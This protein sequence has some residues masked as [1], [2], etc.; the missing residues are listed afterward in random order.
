MFGPFQ[1]SE[2]SA[3]LQ[4]HCLIGSDNMLAIAYFILDLDLGL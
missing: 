1:A 3:F 2:F 4:F